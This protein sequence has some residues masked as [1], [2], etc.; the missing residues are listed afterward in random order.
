MPLETSSAPFRTG[1]PPGIE[2][3]ASSIALSNVDLPPP[4]G[5][6]MPSTSPSLYFQIDVLQYGA[7]IIT[8]AESFD[9]DYLTGHWIAS[10]E[11]RS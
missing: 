1:G 9:L 6:T 3:D 2:G 10:H 8:D 5:P 4:F 7:A 11:S